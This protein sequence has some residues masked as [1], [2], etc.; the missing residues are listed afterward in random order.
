[1][2]E[3]YDGLTRNQWTGTWSPKGDFPIVLS[4]E[5]RGGIHFV[6]GGNS[7]E[8]LQG[9]HGQRLQEGMLAYVKEGYTGVTGDMFYVY[10]LLS[11]ESRS[12]V[13]GEVPNT[14]SNWSEFAPSNGDVTPENISLSSISDVDLS[15]AQSGAILQYNGNTQKWE[16]RNEIDTLFGQLNL[17][18]GVY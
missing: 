7:G 5:V 18:G 17:N 12:Q 1:M 13:T 4:N 6:K 15:S 14:L 11:G 10:K 9:I 2:A 8:T 16:A 3:N